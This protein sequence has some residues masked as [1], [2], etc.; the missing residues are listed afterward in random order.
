MSSLNG[1]SIVELRDELLQA[2]KAVATH[3][4]PLRWAVFGH[5]AN[6]VERLAEDHKRLC[7]LLEQQ[8]A[9]RD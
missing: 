7:E 2:T 4:H 6:R 5:F 1:A 8:Q 3:G 9:V